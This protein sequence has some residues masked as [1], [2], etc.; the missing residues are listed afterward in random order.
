MAKNV[1][2]RSLGRP[3]PDAQR[4]RNPF[5]RSTCVKLNQKAGHAV[6]AHWFWAPAGS[7]V[8]INRKEFMR[9][10]NIITSSFVPFTHYLD[11]FAVKISDLW[12]YWDNWYLNIN[13][14]HSSFGN[15]MQ[16]FESSGSTPV[17]DPV[18]MRQDLPATS[19]RAIL[20][21]LDNSSG[22]MPYTGETE[23]G[24]ETDYD[25][26]RKYN[27][28]RLL[29]NLRYPVSPCGELVDGYYC[30]MEPDN[31]GYVSDK[32]NQVQNYI[33]LCA[34]QKC[35][36]EWYRNT[37]YFAQNPFAFNLD[38]MGSSNGSQVTTENMQKFIGV[39][40]NLHSVNWRKDFY[41]S[42][43][44]ALDYIP[45]DQ[46][47][48][49]WTVPDNVANAFAYLQY[50]TGID[51]DWAQSSDTTSSV[52]GDPGNVWLDITNSKLRRTQSASLSRTTN[53]DHS[54]QQS[55]APNAY[56][57]Q[58][59]RAAFA[60]DKLK[61]ATAYASQHIKDQ[62]EAR[63]GFK[64]KGDQHHS[65]RIGSFKTKIT[66]FEVT[67]T[68]ASEVNG[69][70][71]PLG[72]IGGKGLGS[73]GYEDEIS[74]DCQN[75]DYLIMAISYFVPDL[76]YDS[77]HHDPFLTKH[78]RNDFFQPEFENL[79]LQPVYQ[80]YI[81]WSVFTDPSQAD[82][83]NNILRFYQTRYQEYKTDV[84]RNFGLFNRGCL[85]SPF[86][87]HFNLDLR[88]FGLSGLDWR[89]FKVLPTDVD[90]MFVTQSDPTQLSDHF[91]GVIDFDIKCTQ[92][93]SVHGQPDL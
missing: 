63:F 81:S 44:P 53:H 82:V 80:K 20:N 79:G 52:V 85:L 31:Y 16:F 4:P 49:D 70:L 65:I 9:T 71:Q 90:N 75:C 23:I 22:I 68:S 91:Y 89:F 32:S 51:Q 13:D 2:S 50:T 64:F 17:T 42:A 38:W 60:L 19:M 48:Y 39:I 61:R 62:Y 55:L 5:N 12:S 74:F 93:M 26:I 30:G 27:A 66:P 77:L 28:R 7:H 45:A 36:F 56:N 86:T 43:Y 67:S 92:L 73:A 83:A 87:S 41:Q 84:D 34:Y 15:G 25:E 72:T 59:I 8:K 21:L 40:T 88:V 54:F 58:A 1:G 47:Q 69:N 29:N 76:S 37:S 11:F 6:P 18:K 33:P 14:Q 3:I 24:E 10:F 46:K 35:C 78:S 57:V